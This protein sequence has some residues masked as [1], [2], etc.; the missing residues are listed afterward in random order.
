MRFCG[1]QGVQVSR[2]LGLIFLGLGFFTVEGL[3][4]FKPFQGLG[5]VRVQGALGFK[6]FQGSGFSRVQ[7]LSGLKVF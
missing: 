5:Y 6:P 7:V 2:L 4:R 3:L 1:V